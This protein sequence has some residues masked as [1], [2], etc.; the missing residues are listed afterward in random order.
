MRPGMPSEMVAR[1]SVR[2]WRGSSM[3][4]I[5]VAPE[6]PEARALNKG[7]KRN[8]ISYASSVVIGVASTAPGYSLAAVLGLI[9]AIGGVGVHAPAVL[10]VSFVPMLLVALAYKYLNQADPDAGTTFSWATRAFG[11]ATGWM[12]GWAIVV[13]DVIVMANLAQ[14]AGLYTF[15]LFGI[16][17]PSVVA[18][19]GV[20][21]AWIAVMTVV[22]VIGIEVNARTQRWLLTAELVTLAAFAAV[23]LTRVWAGDAPAGAI[24]PSLSWFSPFAVDSV[25]ALTSGLLIGVFIYWGW[26][27]L[28]TVNEE[29]ED[30]ETVPGRAA[31]LSTLILVGIYVIVSAAAI[32][33]GGID[34]LAGDQSGDVLGLLAGDVFGSA[35][36]GKVVIIAVL[37][38]AAAST[39]TTILPTSRTALSMARAKAAPEP[40][41]HVHPRYLTPHVATWVMGGLSIAWYVGLTI[42]SQNILFDSIAALGLMIA[43]YYGLTGFACAWYYRRTLTRSLGRFLAVGLAPFTGGAIL[44]FV[45]VRSCIDLGRA[46]AGSTTY[47]GIGSPLVIGVGFLVL[48][49]VLMAIWRAAGHR[50]FFARRREAAAAG[51]D[52][53]AVVAPHDTPAA[54]RAEEPLPAPAM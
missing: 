16:D 45:F 7:L 29:T 14:I 28:V 54:H 8:A 1:L 12:G 40:L 42:V 35:V 6:P 50:E 3:A 25:G 23:A 48:G 18:V 37:T 13:A 33:F 19:T 9:V 10:V 41:G 27:S 31:V 15:L 47:F 34:R 43:F 52:Q 5:G 26:D 24:D 2:E 32:A 49:L 21:I 39:Q 38:S 4:E 46:D 30:A 22:C 53:S 11:P 44:L 51:P 17:D 20:G 36:L